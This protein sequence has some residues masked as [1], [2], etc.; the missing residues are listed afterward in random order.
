LK[1]RPNLTYLLIIEISGIVGAN[2]YDRACVGKENFGSFNPR[3]KKT[4]PEKI[5]EAWLPRYFDKKLELRK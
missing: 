5:I 3:A 4:A 1:T 2:N